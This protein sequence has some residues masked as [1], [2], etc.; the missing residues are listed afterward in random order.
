MLREY[1][2]L[3][4][5]GDDPVGHDDMKNPRHRKYGADSFKT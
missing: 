3:A 2:S 4:S 5:R 1:L